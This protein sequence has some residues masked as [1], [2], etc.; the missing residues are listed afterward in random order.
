MLWVLDWK[1]IS[2]AKVY[3]A[4]L[5]QPIFVFFSPLLVTENSAN[6]TTLLLHLCTDLS[7]TCRVAW[8]QNADRHGLRRCI[9]TICCYR[10]Q[11]CKTH[12]AHYGAA[13][14]RMPAIR[15]YGPKSVW[16]G[17][18]VKSPYV[19][20]LMRPDS[21]KRMA[22]CLE[23]YSVLRHYRASIEWLFLQGVE[24]WEDKI[25]WAPKLGDKLCL[26]NAHV[27]RFTGQ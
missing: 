10:G 20:L 11:F 26:E 6:T 4:W 24:D 15:A 13:V 21:R 12:W 18:P 7:A 5:P 22:R 16:N 8:C 9:S 23:S 14:V 2:T 25:G 27:I 1:A 19:G 3:S 17:R